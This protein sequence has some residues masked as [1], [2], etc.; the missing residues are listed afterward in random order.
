MVNFDTE[1]E[2][3]DKS[4]GPD[5]T[6]MIDMVFLLLIFFLLTS[7]IIRPA[8][9]VDFP[10]SETAESREPRE[11]SVTIERDGDIFV[12]DTSVTMETLEGELT[13]LIEET[14]LRAVTIKADRKVEFELIVSVMDAARK[15][16][17]ESVSFVVQKK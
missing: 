1:Q 7:L 9:E 3:L 10:E 6:P 4:S 5:M 16:G 12:N 14:G 17:A 8:L 11:L 15:T 13:A 2:L